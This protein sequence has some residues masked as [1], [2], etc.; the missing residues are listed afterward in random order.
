MELLGASKVVTKSNR[1]KVSVVGAGMQ[2]NSGVAAKMFEALAD[3]NINIDMITTSEIKIS[4]IISKDD[5]ERASKAVHD[6]F[7]N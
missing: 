6:A 7:F 2:S 5:S 4:V 3:A 1:S